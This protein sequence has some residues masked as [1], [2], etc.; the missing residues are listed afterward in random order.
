VEITVGGHE[1]K[2]RDTGPGIAPDVLAGL[3]EPFRSVGKTG[4][5]GLG[6]AY[7]QRVMK[8]F[9]GSIRCASV[10]GES[11]EFA[12][13]FPPVAEARR[14]EH[15]SAVLEA[16]RSGLTG[17]RVLLVEDDPVQ[18]VVTRQKLQPLGV[19][20]EE[21]TD[22]EQALARL[23]AQD[24]DLV[25]L[26]LHMPVLDGYQVALQVRQ[27]GAPRNRHV[28]MVAHSSEPA[29]VARVKTQR[30]GMDAFIS[31]PCSQLVLASALEE[32]LRRRAPSP[33][34]Q[35]LQ[36]RRLLLADDSAFNR[37]AVAA[38][39]REAGAE[40]QEVDHGMGVL[41]QLRA[42]GA[43]D[44]V[45]MDLNMPGLDGLEAARAIRASG[46]PW[47]HLPVVALT[48]HSDAP[49]IAAARAAGM[50][51]FLVKPV[52]AQQL[53]DVLGPLLAGNRP[54]RPPVVDA[55]AVAARQDDGPL[56]NASR[57]ESYQRLGLLEELLAD[58]LPEI[59]RLVQVLAEAV[60][61]QQPDRA[62]DA[63]HS[64]LGLSGEA[65]A[66]ALYQHVR[67]IYV[68]VLEQGRWP[69][70]DWLAQLE[71]LAGRSERALREHAAQVAQ[72]A[73]TA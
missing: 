20:L 33:S 14:E 17:K 71:D 30:A 18:R 42:G 57:L 1:V 3:F 9:G 62:R 59:G 10:L 23:N 56:L 21:A 58:Y 41:E 4:G 73:R 22:G 24:Y 65:G 50:D 69:E 47:A 66:L 26:D 39:L 15:S 35:P 43:F 28:R 6:L 49:A 7:C 61:A 19:A 11:T 5:T 38:Y 48:A 31:K 52:D 68:P 72:Q 45:L 44:A 12:M 64:L 54:Q 63:L 46:A 60:Q 29:H 67:R 8:A 13:Q 55:P 16:A 51:A 53:Y 37:R 70:G 25:L 27:G 40:V 34:T 2:V 32:V 36:G